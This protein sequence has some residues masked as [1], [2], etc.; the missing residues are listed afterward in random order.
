MWAIMVRTL[1]TANQ[2]DVYPGE[3]RRGTQVRRSL[4]FN[5]HIN[6]HLTVGTQVK[7]TEA[8]SWRRPGSGMF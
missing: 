2:V 3:G 8:V 6:N 4:D 1:E 5:E 7:N